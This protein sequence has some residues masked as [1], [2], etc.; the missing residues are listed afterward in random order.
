MS[1]GKLWALDRRVFRTVV[2]R[3]IDARKGI[4]RTL[5]KVEL[6][7]CLN[8]VQMQRLV[9]LLVEDVYPENHYIIRQGEVGDNF[10]LIVKG[11][12]DCTINGGASASE[13]SSE[14]VVMQL[15]DND[16]FG[17]KALLT[18]NPRAANVI[19]RTPTKV[20]YINKKAFE[21]VLGPLSEIIDRDRERREAIS[22]IDSSLQYPQKLAD[23]TMLGVVSQEPSSLI[24]LGSFGKPSASSTSNQANVSVRSFLLNEA[25][26]LG[27]S[28]AVIASIDIARTVTGFTP[29]NSSLVLPRLLTVIRDPNAFHLVIGS[30]IVCDLATIVL[31]ANAR[32][33]YPESATTSESSPSSSQ[34]P[35]Q[36]LRQEVVAYIAGSIVSGL[37]QLHSLGIA[38]RAIQ[39]ESIAVDVRGFIQFTD[40]R[41]SKAGLTGE[42]KTFTICGA[43]DYLAPEQISQR[44]HGTP[45][46]LWALGTLLYELSVG[47]H[48][49]GSN[50]EVA[51]YT[52]ISTFGSKSFPSLPFPD[53]VSS[54]IKAIINQLL[55]PTPEARLGAGVGGFDALKKHALF[56]GF[57]WKALDAMKSPLQALAVAEL[58]EL[59]REGVDPKLLSAF[60]ADYTASNSVSSNWIDLID[61]EK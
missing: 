37:E 53:Y 28:S 16:Y 35:Q 5:K 57:D 26:R 6:L 39:P 7:K 38:Y 18:A 32:A 50:G 41:V 17:E 25:D 40:Y 4:I 59:S 24:L 13:G 58:E 49:F 1:D 11:S 14:T 30:A 52:K 15:K 36:P 51:T 61:I 3:S 54:E 29:A 46:D 55:V 42:N 9:D 33:G 8:N 2:M 47:T 43:T 45:V 56:R 60:D 48:P 22:K 31:S 20:L 23:I 34:T 44:G 27:I 21:E 12:C 10:Y 19:A